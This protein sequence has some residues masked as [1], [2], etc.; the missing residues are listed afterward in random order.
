MTFSTE[1]GTAYGWWRKHRALARIF[2]EADNQAE[3]PC[4]R[5]PNAVL[6]GVRW[7]AC[8]DF[9]AYLTLGRHYKS[10]GRDRK[11]DRETYDFL[12]AVH[13]GVRGCEASCMPEDAKRL[14]WG[15]ARSG[16]SGL[17]DVCPVHLKTRT[18]APISAVSERVNGAGARNGTD[19]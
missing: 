16:C 4:D 15:F 2:L 6:C 19:D 12:F 7:L 5:C 17:M 1:S 8:K 9:A 18:T 10:G 14:G 13:C 11:P 3:A